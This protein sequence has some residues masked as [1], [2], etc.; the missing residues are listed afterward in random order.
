MA[1]DR[2]SHLYDITGVLYKI[3]KEL[4]YKETTVQ[5]PKVDWE[6]TAQISHEHIIASSM[7]LILWYLFLTC[8]GV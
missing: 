7:R 4:H 5:Q 3:N 8:G 2:M 1:Q 6:T